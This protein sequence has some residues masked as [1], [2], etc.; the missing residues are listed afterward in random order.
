MSTCKFIT[1]QLELEPSPNRNANKLYRHLHVRNLALR[2]IA[3]N[4]ARMCAADIH[5]CTYETL[6]D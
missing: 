1:V 6:H 4:I 2:R 3:A 5:S